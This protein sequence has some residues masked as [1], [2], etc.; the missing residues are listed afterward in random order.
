[1]K[2]GRDIHCAQRM[3]P[4]DF[5]DLLHLSSAGDHQSHKYN[6]MVTTNALCQSIQKM[7]SWTNQQ[8][9]IADN[10]HAG[11]INKKHTVK[12]RK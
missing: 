2:F 5:G 8:T 3:N 11:S 7:V 10:S 4:Y 6:F 1:M 12:I 9:E